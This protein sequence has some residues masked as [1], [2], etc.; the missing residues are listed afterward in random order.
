MG[1]KAMSVYLGKFPDLMESLKG[2]TSITPD[3]S[4]KMQLENVVLKLTKEQNG[5]FLNYDGLELPW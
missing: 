5:K 1:E 4:V 2:I 3:E